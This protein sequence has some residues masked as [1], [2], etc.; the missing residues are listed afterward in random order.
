MLRRK[1]AGKV[2][3]LLMLGI[4]GLILGFAC[5]VIGL[6]GSVVLGSMGAALAGL[7]ILVMFI[8]G[9]LALGSLIYG[10]KQEKGDQKETRITTLQNVQ[11]T[12]RFA[13]NHI[14]ETLFDADYIE[15]DHPKTKLYVR[16]NAPGSPQVELRTN[17]DVWN[18]CGEGMRGHAHV[19]G[20]WLGRFEQVAMPPPTGNPYIK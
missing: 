1:D 7:G 5:I 3:N 2:S 17:A 8:G 12:A 4:G 19:Q 13:T 20:D 10:L 6:L 16:V 14:G 15:F 11:I 9:G 18:A